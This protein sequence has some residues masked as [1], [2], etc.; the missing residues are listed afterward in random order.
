MVRAR[1]IMTKNVITVHMD[2]PIDKAVE[3]LA[4][5]D[6]TGMPVVDEADRLIGIITEQDLMHLFHDESNLLYSNPDEHKKTVRDFMS[7][8]VIFF[9]EDESVMDVCRCLKNY[10]FRRVPIT[11]DK[12][13]VGLISRQ[14]IIK[15]VLQKRREESSVDQKVLET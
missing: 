7:G 1:D 11:S 13:V 8:D 15:Y 4:E 12:K 14:D 3:L 6:I 2:T 10:H 5:M 9:E